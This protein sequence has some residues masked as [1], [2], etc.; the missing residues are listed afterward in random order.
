M[1]ESPPT[2][3]AGEKVHYPIFHDETCVHA[4]DLANYVWMREGEQPLRNKSRGRIVHVSDF[5]IEASGRLS[6]NS[7]E[8]RAQM[9]LPTCPE[10]PSAST[11]QAS[12]QDQIPIAGHEELNTSAPKKKGRGKASSSKSKNTNEASSSKLKSTKK[13]AA[14]SSTG[15]T[16]TEQENEWVPPPPPAPFSSY[17]LSSFDARRI[18]YPGA[19][20]DP[21]WDMTQLIEQVCVFL[22]RLV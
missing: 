5:I 19:N 12:P 4:N 17:R 1:A 14:S 2:V 18:I 13:T 20:Y 7:E 6:L 15:R 10:R 16:Y 22:N 3:P 11:T 21:W 9:E 8:I